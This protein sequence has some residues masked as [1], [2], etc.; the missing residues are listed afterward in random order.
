MNTALKLSAYGPAHVDDHAATTS[1]HEPGG[2]ASTSD[3]YTFVPDTTTL[4]SGTFAFRITGPDGVPV[5][6]FDQVHDRQLHLIVVRRD[7]TGFQHV[8]PERDEHRRRLHR[9]A[10]RRARSRRHVAAAA[11]R[12]PRRG[13]R[14]RSA[15]LPRRVRPPRGP[16]RRRPGL[17]ARAPRQHGDV[18]A[19][20]R[21]RRRGAQRRDLPDV[22]RL[23]GRRSRAD[24][25]LHR[26][27]GGEPGMST[28]TTTEIELSLGGMTCASCA[29][30]IERKL[31]KL[32]GV[33]AS[34]NYATEKARVQAPADL[35]PAVLVAQVEAAGYT[36]TLPA[37]PAEDVVGV[38][39][40]VAER[41]STRSL[42][43]RLV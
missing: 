34:V 26:D 12:H 23:P 18:R 39:V 40:A 27:D 25:R 16:A 1:G 32:D 36:A 38:A 30:R 9:D 42:R 31:N 5:T 3:G 13:A 11:D 10:R 35:D 21:V 37:P 2:L 6:A 33:Q 4:G 19:R 43:D 29:N 7:A 17:P 15:A 14:D 28:P 41:D 22:L 20:G 8:H 24:G